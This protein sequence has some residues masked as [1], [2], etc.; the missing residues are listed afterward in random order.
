MKWL[1]LVLFLVLF[2]QGIVRL[3]VVYLLVANT[4]RQPALA[5]FARLFGIKQN[6]PDLPRSQVILMVLRQGITG[7]ASIDISIFAVHSIFAK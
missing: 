4:R 7:I 2:V 6:Q 3:F 1:G 5:K